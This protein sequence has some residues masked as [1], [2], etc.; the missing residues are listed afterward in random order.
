M[1]MYKVSNW[2]YPIVEV[3][4][5]KVTDHHVWIDGI[6]IRREGSFTTYFETM[7]QANTVKRIRCEKILSMYEKQIEQ[8]TYFIKRA[9]SELKTLNK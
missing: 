7:K 2:D 6:R 1:K 9:Q 4:A 5:T 8:C 3:E